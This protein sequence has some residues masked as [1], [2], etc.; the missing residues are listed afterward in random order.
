MLRCLESRSIAY[1][2]E[3][4]EYETCQRFEEF[5]RD[6]LRMGIDVR[7]NLR[8]IGE[9]KMGE[10]LRE[11][12]ERWRCPSCGKPIIVSEVIDHCHTCGVKLRV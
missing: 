7:E 5:A 4:P 9:G 6:N 10:W 12:E 3:C 11:Q 8:I 1:C 2:C